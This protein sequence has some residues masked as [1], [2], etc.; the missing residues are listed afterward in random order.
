MRNDAGQIADKNCQC[1]KAGNFRKPQAASLAFSI[2]IAILP[3]CPFC[4]FGYSGVMVLCSGTRIYDQHS[5]SYWYL[6]VFVAIAVVGSLLWNYRGRRTWWALVLAI[7]GGILVTGA[8]QFG[9]PEPVYYIGAGLIFWGVF[10]NGSFL[11]F[12]KKATQYL[13]S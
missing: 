10:V 11:P 5:V 13:H 2:L 9:T 6:P 8:R 7:A 12:W 1:K 3:K 4:V